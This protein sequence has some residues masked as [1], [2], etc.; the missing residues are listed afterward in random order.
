MEL[1]SKE[2]VE[3]HV[4]ELCHE[5]DWG[6]WELWWSTSA[7]TRPGQML[8]LKGIFLDVISQLVSAGKL[9]AKHKREDGNITA[10]EYHREKLAREIDFSD[11]PD[12][13]SYFWFGTE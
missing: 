4:I 9:I 1:Q 13:D 6:S 12:P 5:D 10:T 2:S 11:N 3:A 7:E 8:V